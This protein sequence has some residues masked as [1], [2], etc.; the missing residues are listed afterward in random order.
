MVHLLSMHAAATITTD[1]TTTRMVGAMPVA[2]CQVLA[3]SKGKIL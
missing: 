2:I 3:L 1:G